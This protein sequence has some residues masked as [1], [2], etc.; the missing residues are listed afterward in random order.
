LV[1]CREAASLTLA[2][3]VP[4]SPARSSWPTRSSPVSQKAAHQASAIHRDLKPEKILLA[5]R[6]QQ[7]YHL[8]GSGAAVERLGAALPK[9][10]AKDRRDRY[11]EVAEMQQELTPAIRPPSSRNWEKG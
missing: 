6:V 11:A 9:C 2:R 10:L 5:Q 3:T 4:N 8:P 1:V 7:P